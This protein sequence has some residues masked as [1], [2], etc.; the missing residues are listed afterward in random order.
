[1]I[2]YLYF[3]IQL[4]KGEWYLCEKNLLMNNIRLIEVR[5]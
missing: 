2:R 5:N 4:R 1:M 3:Y